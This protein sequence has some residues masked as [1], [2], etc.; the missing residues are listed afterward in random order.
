MLLSTSIAVLSLLGYGAA[1]ADPSVSQT[2]IASGHP[3]G[4]GRRSADAANLH[5]REQ[6]IHPL[7]RRRPF[8]LPSEVSPRKGSM[9]PTEHSGQE[10]PRSH[11]QPAGEGQRSY[12]PTHRRKTG[13]GHRSR[14]ADWNYKSEE[15]PSPP[16]DEPWKVLGM[17]EPPH[18]APQHK[19]S[20]SFKLPW[21][22]L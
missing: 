8:R 20:G 19:S 1:L 3:E 6:D 2:V 7:L 11:G 12:T 14:Q 18:E 4:L 21:K 10:S 13:Y 15:F 22:P 5:H 16:K 17:K 9:S